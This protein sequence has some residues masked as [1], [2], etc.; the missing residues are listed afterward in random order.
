MARAD[1][2][3]FAQEVEID[4]RIYEALAEFMVSDQ[5]ATNDLTISCPAQHS[6]M[7][8]NYSALPR[9]YIS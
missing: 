4:E 9:H 8:V 1:N 3:P 7:W 6:S 5:A 2:F